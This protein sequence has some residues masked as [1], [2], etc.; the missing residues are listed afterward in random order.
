VI[1]QDMRIA[2]CNRRV[3]LGRRVAEIGPPGGIDEAD[4]RVAL[5]QSGHQGHA[6]GVDHLRT[7]FFELVAVRCNSPYPLTVQQDVG[8]V[9]CCSGTVKHAAVRKENARH[10]SLPYRFSARPVCGRIMRT[11]CHTSVND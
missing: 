10:Q 3:L 8:W 5:D 6:G 9:G 2:R 1:Q 4:V 11:P 7:A